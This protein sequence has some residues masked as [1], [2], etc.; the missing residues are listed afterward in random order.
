MQPH[1]RVCTYAAVITQL[2]SHGALTPLRRCSSSHT[3]T[4]TWP[5]LCCS[6]LAAPMQQHSRSSTY[7]VALT[8]QHLRAATF[9]GHSIYAAALT[10]QHSSHR[11]LRCR[12]ALT[13]RQALPHLRC[14]PRAGALQ[15]D[16]D[17]LELLF[18]RRARRGRA[19]A[20]LKGRRGRGG[21]RAVVR[22][23]GGVLELVGPVGGDGRVKSRVLGVGF[24]AKKRPHLDKG[25][26][27][28]AKVL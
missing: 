27:K 1:S 9:F 10:L 5:L 23:G 21:G 7:A 17:H 14:S 8:L 18:Q 20:S 26:E 13:L 28:W 15:V 22:G 24:K 16:E 6:I 11:I 12:S 19:E 2:T 4:F 3:V 25:Y